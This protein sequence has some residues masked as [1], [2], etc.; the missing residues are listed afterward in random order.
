ME[1][2][3][4]RELV[5]GDKLPVVVVGDPGG[6]NIPEY[7]REAWLGTEFSAEPEVTKLRDFITDE[8]LEPQPVWKVD[9]IEA[10]HQLRLNGQDEA[11]DWW[12]QQGLYEVGEVFCFDIRSCQ[13]LT[14]EK[15]VFPELNWH[16]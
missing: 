14:G 16:S 15:I 12:V 5:P 9:R 13:P 2:P 4:T 7:I 8:P 3:L 6:P 11:A 1:L 10:I